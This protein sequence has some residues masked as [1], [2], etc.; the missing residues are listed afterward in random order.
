[1]LC[2]R[3]PRGFYRYAIHEDRQVGESAT[4]T[5]R[6]TYELLKDG[7]LRKIRLDLTSEREVLE[8]GTTTLT[9]DS[10]Q[11]LIDGEYA[12][13]LYEQDGKLRGTK[14][15]PSTRQFHLFGGRPLLMQLHK[16]YFVSLLEDEL[17]DDRP[18]YVIGAM[19]EGLP[20][21][22]SVVCTSPDSSA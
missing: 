2:F 20:W 4:V 22:F 9:D 14:T 3:V 18:A 15:N 5:S 19:T 12:Y 8:D 6:G 21:W 7:K 16:G 17:V 13:H 10:S 11:L 1:M